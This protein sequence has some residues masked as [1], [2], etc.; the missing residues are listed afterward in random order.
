MEA[1][2][3]K[4]ELSFFFGSRANEKS[5]VEL[6]NQQISRF[7]ILK[8]DFSDF[9]GPPKLNLGTKSAIFLLLQP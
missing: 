4:D 7:A 9:E 1:L 2:F 3:S 6:E 5:D 8:W